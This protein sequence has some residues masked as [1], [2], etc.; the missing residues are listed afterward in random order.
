MCSYK[1]DCYKLTDCKHLLKLKIFTRF[2]YEMFSE[3]TRS[4]FPLLGI[5]VL[6]RCIAS[7]FEFFWLLAFSLQQ[8]LCS[9]S[10]FPLSNFSDKTQRLTA[11]HFLTTAPFLP[12]STQCN[13]SNLHLSAECLYPYI[14]RNFEQDI[15]P[16]L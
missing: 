10:M 8:V 9:H 6:C 5:R 13:I 11:V 16:S 14:T 3:S 7:S 15:C 1:S 12:F 2:W 4:T